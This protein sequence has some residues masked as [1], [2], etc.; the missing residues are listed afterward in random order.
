VSRSSSGVVGLLAEPERLRVVSA[1]A[2]GATTIPEVAAAAG[3]EPRAVVRALRRLERGGLVSR[4]K[5]ELTLHAGRFKEAAREAAPDEAGEP[6]SADPATDAVL[7]AFTRDGRIVSFPVQ[8]SR[9]RLLLE[10]VAAVFEPGVRYPEKEVNATLR[11]WYADYAALRRYLVDEALLDRADGLYWRIGGP[12][13]VD[14]AAA[15]VPVERYQRVA[16]YGIA[17][18]GESVLL[19]RLS[20]SVHKGRWTLPG[21]GLDFGERPVD[22][23]VREVHEETGLHVRVEELLDADA[24]LWD[25]VRDGVR[26]EAHSVR[27]VYRV[28]V[29][30]GTLGVVEVD[31]STE[32]AAWWPV[33]GLPP[34]TPMAE[35]MLRTGRV[36][37]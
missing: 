1:L 19:S 29:L 34:L 37:P 7:R 24:E 26:R 27:F 18:D 8:R 14:A 30:G 4:S 36:N 16:A 10:H 20:R 33:S 35:R 22:A 21:G 32:A 17:R 15:E 3:M 23:V 12:V 11:A 5:D 9:R 13:A 28:T 2:L 25:F 31:G 6:L